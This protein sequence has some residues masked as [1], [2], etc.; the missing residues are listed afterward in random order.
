MIKLPDHYAQFPAY[1]RKRLNGQQVGGLGRG[2]GW[3]RRRKWS[4]LVLK[5]RAGRKRLY[6][7]Y[8]EIYYTTH[9][10]EVYIIYTYNI[11][12]YKGYIKH[13]HVLGIKERN[14]G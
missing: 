2:G 14:I 6:I 9:F 5:T 8:T 13:I 12:R 11:E 7:I 1:Y 3:N 10:R 4:I